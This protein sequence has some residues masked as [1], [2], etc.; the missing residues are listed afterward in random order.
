MLHI[1]HARS[2]WQ[3]IGKVQRSRFKVTEGKHSFF[4]YACT[5]WGATYIL[6]HQIAAPNVHATLKHSLKCLITGWLVLKFVVVSATSTWGLS[7]YDLLLPVAF[8]YISQNY[9]CFE[10]GEFPICKNFSIDG[11]NV[12][13]MWTKFQPVRTIPWGIVAHSTAQN[14]PDNFH[15]YPPDN[16]HCSNDVYLREGEITMIYVSQSSSMLC[17]VCSY[18]TFCYL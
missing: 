3:N 4:S 5:F 10:L 11:A 15:S 8:L 6:N 17:W 9:T 1:C 14:R 16:H 2:P 18:S 13:Y 7:V 12:G